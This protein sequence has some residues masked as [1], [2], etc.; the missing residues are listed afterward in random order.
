MNIVKNFLVRW[1][2]GLLVHEFF[3]QIPYII[4]FNLR[5]LPWRQ[6]KRLPIF[7]H[8]R[9]FGTP[10]GRIAIEAD[11]VSPGMIVLGAGQY[12]YHKSG[13][14]LKNE[15]RII[16]KGC[17]WI[18][19]ETIIHVHRNAQLVLGNETGISTAKILCGRSIEIGEHTIVGISSV[20]MDSDFHPVVDIAG[21]VYVNPSRPVKIGSYNWLGSET[22]VL[23]GA[24]TPRHVI[25]SARSV[26]NRKY[27]IPE[28]SCL[29]TVSGKEVVMEGYIRNWM[30]GV[31][32]AFE[33]RKI[34]DFEKL[35]KELEGNG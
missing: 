8:V 1:R 23:K 4:Y 14:A 34:E 25:V 20:L 24:Q 11:E 27:R 13:I 21:R 28:F 26:L 2:I 18:S 16:F 5:Y 15:G 3:F 35:L 31:R 6:A 32:N 29:S 33:S 12:F 22:M 9:T 19:N 7:L 10:K 17:C 30:G